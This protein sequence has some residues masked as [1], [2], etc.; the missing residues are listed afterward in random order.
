MDGE[1]HGKPYEQMG[2]FGGKPPYFLKPPNASLQ[3]GPAEWYCSPKSYIA[4]G[5]VAIFMNMWAMEPLHMS[6]EWLEVATID[7]H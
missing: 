3:W 5:K 7:I 1:N 4:G 6:F 2:W